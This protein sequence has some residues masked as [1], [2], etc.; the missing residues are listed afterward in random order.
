MSAGIFFSNFGFAIMIFMLLLVVIFLLNQFQ[1][2]SLNILSRLSATYNE[3][4][5]LLVRMTNSLDAVNAKVAELE[6]RQSQINKLLEKQSRQI[7]EI[8]D[9]FSETGQMTKAIDLARGG[10]TIQDI[11][12]ATK[13]PEEEAE[14]IVKFHGDSN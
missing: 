13:L 8:A 9:G 14:A 6:A 7:S 5:I 1:K 2:K 4:E 12:L 10:A 3:I 11:M